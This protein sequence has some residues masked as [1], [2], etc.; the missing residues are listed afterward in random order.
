VLVDVQQARDQPQVPGDR[1]LP[2]QDA[3]QPPF[4]LGRRLVDLPVTADDPLGGVGVAGGQRDQ[5]VVELRLHHPAEGD[6]PAM[7]IGQLLVEGCSHA[8]NKLPGAARRANCSGWC[9]AQR[10]KISRL[11]ASSRRRTGGVWWRRSDGSPRCPTS[12]SIVWRQRTAGLLT[13]RVMW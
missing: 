2:G 5:S 1:R 8:A 3:Q 13:M 7:E 6:Q 11:Q 10:V 9:P 12:G 4:D